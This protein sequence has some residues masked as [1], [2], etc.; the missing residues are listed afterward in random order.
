MGSVNEA[1]LLATNPDPSQS[2]GIRFWQAYPCGPATLSRC[3]LRVNE[4]WL[5][6]P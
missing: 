5:L 2:I 3:S 4:N 6:F 1:R